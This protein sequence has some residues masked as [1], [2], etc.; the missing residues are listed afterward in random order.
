MKE[1]YKEKLKEKTLEEIFDL[2]I[3]GLEYEKLE[4]EQN[5]KINVQG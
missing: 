4:K 1:D 2:L 5:K 3:I